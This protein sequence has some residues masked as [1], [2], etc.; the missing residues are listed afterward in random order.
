MSPTEIDWAPFEAWLHAE[1]IHAIAGAI[2]V[3]IGV[4]TIKHFVFRG[5]K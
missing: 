4:W 2:A 3:G 1:I 5:D